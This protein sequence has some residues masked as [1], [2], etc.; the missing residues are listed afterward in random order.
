MTNYLAQN[1]APLLEQLKNGE[2]KLLGI[3]NLTETDDYGNPN[4]TFSARTAYFMP[5]SWQS[6]SAE[7]ETEVAAQIRSLSFYKITIAVNYNSLPVVAKNSDRLELKAYFDGL[8]QTTKTLEVKD[9]ST[10]GVSLSIIAVD[11]SV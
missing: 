11:I 8:T 4:L 5:C 3:N 6:K 1:F 9:V 7:N 2:C 10:D